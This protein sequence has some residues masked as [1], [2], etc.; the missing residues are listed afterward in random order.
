MRSYKE[1]KQEK[2]ELRIAETKKELDQKTANNVTQVERQRSLPRNNGT[3]KINGAERLA[4]PAVIGWQA[5]LLPR[6][7]LEYCGNAWKWEIHSLRVLYVDCRA[8]E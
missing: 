7:S 2:P 5:R 4:R 3:R 8:L 6:E 1:N